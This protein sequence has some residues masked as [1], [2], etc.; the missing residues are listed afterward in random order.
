MWSRE[1][2]T[3]RDSRWQQSGT[4]HIPISATHWP[5]RHCIVPWCFDRVGNKPSV[6]ADLAIYSNALGIFR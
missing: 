5:H 2:W 4:N 6:K 1:K 3:G